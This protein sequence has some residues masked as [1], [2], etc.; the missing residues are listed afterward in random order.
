[1]TKEDSHQKEEKDRMVKQRKRTGGKGEESGGEEVTEA[2]KIRIRSDEKVYD[3]VRF[4]S[5]LTPCTVALAINYT[6]ER[7]RKVL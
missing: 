2:G 1:V 5:A 7:A 3:R 6:T 4:R